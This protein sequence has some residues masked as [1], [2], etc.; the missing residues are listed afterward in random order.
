MRQ[1]R[2]TEVSAVDRPAQEHATAVIIKREDEEKETTMD[3]TGY[4]SVLDVIKS[5]K[6]GV[7]TFAKQELEAGGAP[8]L[9]EF[10]ATQAVTEHF[11]IYHPGSPSQAFAKGIQRSAD[12]PML[13]RWIQSCRDAGFV[14]AAT[15]DPYPELDAAPRF[16]AQP[17]QVGGNEAI[18]DPKSALDQ[19]NELAAEIRAKHPFMTPEQAFARVY[20]DRANADLVARERSENRPFSGANMREHAGGGFEVPNRS[21]PGRQGHSPARSSPGRP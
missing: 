7:I 19:L 10:E 5:H 16:T 3:T 6:N 13:L 1:F 18:R 21:S 2:L 9:S 17:R 14:K 11:K 20:T 15:G 4:D 12:G 8:L